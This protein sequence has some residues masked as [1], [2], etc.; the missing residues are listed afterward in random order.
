MSTINIL[1]NG[2][3][4][5]TGSGNF[6]GSNSPALVTPT[7]GVA[8]ATTVNKVAITQPAT[9]STVTVANGK[10]LTASNTLTA[11]GTDSSSVAFGAGGILLCTNAFTSVVQQ[12]F[13]A[14]G[15]YTPTAG[16][17][18]CIVE[19]W[20]PGGGGGGAA[21]VSSNTSAGGSGSGGSY[22]REIFSAAT[23]GASQAVTLPGGGPGGNS[24]GTT[25]GAQQ[26]PSTFG[27]LLTAIGGTG[28][29]VGYVASTTYALSSYAKVTTDASVGTFIVSG[30]S[31]RPGL[32]LGAGITP[33]SL[34]GGRT[35][36]STSGVA[37]GDFTGN[38][39]GQIGVD[40]GGGGGG[41]VATTAS[42]TGGA[43]GKGRCVITE[44]IA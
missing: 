32:T 31:G 25:A 26:S 10:T 24:A 8:T 33:V 39:S 3:S 35:F 19:L 40:N 22:V 36:P 14:T 11:S 15:T 37:H 16:M 20:G 34:S 43:G 5:V 41:G 7:L 9:G 38:T 21:F 1:N 42:H 27:S 44:F 18:W 17:A 6:V 2:L 4:G 23:I 30:E 13:T 28:C 12:I 29:P